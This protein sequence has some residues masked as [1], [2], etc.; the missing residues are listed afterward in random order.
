MGVKV[1]VSVG[2]GWFTIYCCPEVIAIP[3]CPGEKGRQSPPDNSI[4]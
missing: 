4:S 1:D 2:V 3:G